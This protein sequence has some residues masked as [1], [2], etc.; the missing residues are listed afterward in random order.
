[1]FIAPNEN[2]PQGEFLSRVGEAM[3]LLGGKSL[4]SLAKERKK[5][6]QGESRRSVADCGRDKGGRFGPKNQCQEDGDGTSE[7]QSDA[8]AKSS[9]AIEAD[10]N[11]KVI[12]KYETKHGV[13]EVLDRTDVESKS[14]LDAI[15]EDGADKGYAVSFKQAV[16]LQKDTPLSDGDDLVQAYTSAAYMWFT[17]TTGS[18]S[19]GDEFLDRYG[20]EWGTIDDYMSQEIVSEK[21]TDYENEWSSLSEEEKYGP[22]WE[23]LS[24]GDKSEIESEKLDEKREE[25]VQEVE[26]LRE[27]ARENAANQMRRELES[28]LSSAIIECCMQLYRGMQL[29]PTAIEEM[30]S[31]GFVSHKSSNSWTTSRQVARSFG[32]NRVAIVLRKPRVGH[33]LSSDSLEEKEVIRPPTRLR[34][35]S[36][37]KTSTGYVIHVDEDDD[38]KDM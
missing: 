9:A 29:S 32:A 21:M 26:G 18:D 36:A 7:D 25:F 17:E 34:I 3:G 2:E 23:S 10:A 13:V 5:D 27:A 24:D 31:S 16:A 30:L 38:Y 4:Y 19:N 8:G 14:Y 1:M 33:I 12:A 22:D 37:V 35:V 28:S 11:A 20:A 6:K 15:E